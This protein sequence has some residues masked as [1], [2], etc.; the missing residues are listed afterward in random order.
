MGK[1]SWKRPFGT[2]A[3]RPENT[4]KSDLKEIVYQGVDWINMTQNRDQ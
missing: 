4:I 1:S 3:N 2:R